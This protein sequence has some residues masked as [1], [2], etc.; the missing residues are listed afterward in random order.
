MGNFT[1]LYVYFIGPL[2]GGGLAAIF[3]DRVF[4]RSA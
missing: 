3:Y 4:L 1:D 2:L